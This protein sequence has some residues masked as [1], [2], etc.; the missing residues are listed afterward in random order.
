MKIGIYTLPFTW[1][2]GGVLQAYALQAVLEG[3][4]HEVVIID[5]RKNAGCAR[6]M[7]KRIKWEAIALASKLSICRKHPLVAVESFKRQYLN[8]SP[9]FFY[10]NDL[11]RYCK[12]ERIQAL[13]VGSDQIWRYEA[14]Q[15][16]GNSFGDF[17]GDAVLKIAY[18]VSFGGDD[19]TYPNAATKWCRELLCGFK[20]V[21]LRE[22]SGVEMC[23][24]YFWPL[25]TKNGM[26]PK[27]VIDPVLLAGRDVFLP[28]V[29]KI[30]D[31]SGAKGFIFSYMLDGCNEKELIVKTVAETLDCG[32]VGYMDHGVSPSMER[33][34]SCI[35]RSRF[36]V[37]DSFHGMC[38]SIL[39]NKPFIAIG[40]IKR[41][42]AR[43]IS[44]VNI[45][46]LN[47]RLMLLSGIS[48]NTISDVLQKDICWQ[49]VN[50]R[51]EKLRSESMLFIMN[52][53][54]EKP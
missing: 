41:G 14:A 39:F 31:A 48:K 15:D 9:L 43:F 11:R 42:M 30:A 27:L 29:S 44:L 28:L 26:L 52:A 49:D 22:A 17:V 20:A 6:N 18:A 1:N 47:D 12:R 7:L 35:A 24:K 40:N 50:S 13:I 25:P 16:I 4:G 19:W 23:L 37:T 46:G 54:S 2:Y 32:A 10:A 3:C 33:W 36:V 38:F 8:R 53:L 34:L 45:L 51:I 5:R 21:G